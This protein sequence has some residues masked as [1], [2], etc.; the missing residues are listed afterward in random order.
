MRKGNLENALDVLRKYDTVILL[1]DS[2]SMTMPGSESR[3]RWFEASQALEALAETAAKYDTDSIDIHFLN[4]MTLRDAQDQRDSLTEKT[5]HLGASCKKLQY[6]LQTG[7]STPA[8]REKLTELVEHIQKSLALCELDHLR[9]LDDFTPLYLRF[10]QLIAEDGIPQ[11]SS[12][13]CAKWPWTNWRSRRNDSN[14][15]AL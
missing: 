15:S 3:S 1:D 10:C 14:N 6:L 2:G 13:T 8:V 11:S 5:R 9:D 12:E 7:R 4:G